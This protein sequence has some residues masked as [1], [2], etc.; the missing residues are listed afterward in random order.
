MPPIIHDT[1]TGCGTCY[2]ICPGDVLRLDEDNGVAKVEYPDECWHCG[3][4]RL[5]CPSD[6]ITYYFPLKMV[7]V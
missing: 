6:A 7:S 3:A 4:C 5:E 2:D 1:C